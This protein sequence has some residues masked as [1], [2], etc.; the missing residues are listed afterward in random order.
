MEIQPMNLLSPKG[1]VIIATLERL[2]GCSLIVPGSVRAEPAGGFSFDYE[3][4]TDIYWDEQRTVIENDQRVFV[5]EEGMEYLESELRLV[6]QQQ[7]QESPHLAD[8]GVITVTVE[9][10]V[11]QS[12]D[13]VPRGITVRVLDF[14]TE[15]TE[16]ES[17]TALPNGGKA[18]V[19]EWSG[20][21]PPS[22]D[23]T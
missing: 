19:S 17:L 15:G 23:T 11:V 6:P 4:S 2:S 14:D 8:P 21:P 5:D 16:E 12:V 3:G 7:E 9:G 22:E 20:K 13:G 1:T 10:G 18:Y